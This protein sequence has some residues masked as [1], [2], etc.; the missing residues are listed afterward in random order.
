MKKEKNLNQ[1]EKQKIRSNSRENARN[2]LVVREEERREEKIREEKSGSMKDIF[3][4]LS[5]SA[6][7]EL[8]FSHK[9]DTNMYLPC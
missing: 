8:Q 9:L 3:L 4:S 2:I 1:E 5:R 7:R 6:S